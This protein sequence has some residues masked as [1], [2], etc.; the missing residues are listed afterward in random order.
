MRA[1]VGPKT[2][3]RESK[4]GAGFQDAEGLAKKLGPIRATF[5]VTC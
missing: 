4:E 1:A 3:F 5:M 2:V